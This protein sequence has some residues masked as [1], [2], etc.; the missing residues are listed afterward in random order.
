MRKT[1]SS[2]A[3]PRRATRG[4]HLAV[5]VLLCTVAAVAV[6]QAGYPNRP[7]RVIVPYPPGGNTDVIAREVMREVSARMGQPFV[8]DNK[9]GANGT[10]G[11]DMVAKAP[12]DGY[13][14]GVVI[15][16]YALSPSLYRSLPYQATD[17]APVALMSRTSLVLVASQQ[18]AYKDV[19]ALAKAG[20]A[21]GPLGFGSSGV[22]SAAHLLGTRFA[23]ATDIPATHVPYKGSTDAVNDLVAGR[24]GFMF[25][26][27]SAMG[28]LITQGRLQALAVTSANRS[29]QLPAVPSIAELGYPQLVS[30]AWSGVLA[31]AQTPRPVVERLSAEIAAALRVPAIRERLAAISTE[32]VGSSPAE[33]EAFIREETRVGAEAIRQAGITPE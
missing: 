13:T 27:V 10:I 26:A 33:F 28:G 19:A 7:V 16:A 14:L 29:P 6:A 2:P 1:P 18:A 4:K 3:E 23:R 31:P 30:Y 12:P 20:K 17:L 15:G 8:V 9:P 11:T 22:G 24:I 21:Q 32:A 25:D 5:G